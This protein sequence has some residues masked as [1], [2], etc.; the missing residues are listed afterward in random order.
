M[1]CLLAV[2]DAPQPAAASDDDRPEQAA[3]RAAEQ[4]AKAL[5]IDMTPVKA[6]HEEQRIE[7]TPVGSAALIYKF[8][9]PLCMFH[10]KG[11]QRAAPRA[12][13][14][15]L[16]RSCCRRRLRQKSTKRLAV[17]ITFVIHAGCSFSEG[18]EAC[19]ST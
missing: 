4:R 7:D 14:R 12:S 5:Q 3:A 8:F 13:P 15:A 16:T 9:C 11:E 2:Q 19:R 17:R 6:L 18:K 1:T 10:L